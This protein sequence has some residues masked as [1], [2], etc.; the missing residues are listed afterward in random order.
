MAKQRLADRFGLFAFVA[1][2]PDDDAVGVIAVST[3]GAIYAAC[4]VGTIQE[5]YVAPAWRS[6]GV[7]RELLERVVELGGRSGWNRIEVEPW[8]RT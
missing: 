7:G 3:G 1:L 6:A 5:L 2:G 4:V 8:E